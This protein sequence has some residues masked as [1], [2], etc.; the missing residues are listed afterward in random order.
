MKIRQE[1]NIPI[2]MDGTI[3]QNFLEERDSLLSYKMAFLLSFLKNI[4]SIGDAQNVDVLTDYIDFYSGQDR[5]G[6]PVDGFS[7][8]YN[9]NY[10]ESPE[11]DQEKH[12]NK[13]V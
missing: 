2:H 11:A 5:K 12:D 4:N 3:K 10:T 13:F 1:L 8:P 6:L 7:C 9:E